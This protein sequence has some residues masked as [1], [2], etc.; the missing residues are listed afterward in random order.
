MNL[1]VAIAG[2]LVVILIS[3]MAVWLLE[4]VQRRLGTGVPKMVWVFTAVVLSSVIFNN[5]FVYRSEVV[6]AVNLPTF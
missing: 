3:I 4:R 2:T 5:Y 6:M 1:K